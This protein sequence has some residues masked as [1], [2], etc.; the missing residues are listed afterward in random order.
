MVHAEGELALVDP[1]EAVRR[2][3][4]ITGLDE[5]FV[6]ETSDDAHDAHDAHR[7]TS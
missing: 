4:S 6:V 2:L 3:L 7:S 1:T 5:Q